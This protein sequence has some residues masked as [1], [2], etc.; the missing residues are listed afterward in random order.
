MGAVGFADR[1]K[2][3]L[4]KVACLLVKNAGNW[5]VIPMIRP[6]RVCRYTQLCTTF[7][8]AILV[9]SF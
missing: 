7:H 3:D 6:G 8:A 9:A 4:L 5:T 2:S 1:V